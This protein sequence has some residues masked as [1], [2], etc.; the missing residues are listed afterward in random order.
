MK[1]LQPDSALLCK[2]GSIAIHIQEA[3]SKKGSHFDLQALKPL[4]EDKE[5]NDWLKEMDKLAL[6]PKKR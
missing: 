4:I 1:P 3:F 6:I 2:L 5:V